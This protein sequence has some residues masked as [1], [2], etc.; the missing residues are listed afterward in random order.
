M[1]SN[2]VTAAQV[3]MNNQARLRDYSSKRF[4]SKADQGSQLRAPVSGTSLCPDPGQ[5]SVLLDDNTT[6]SLE[7]LNEILQSL[8]GG[9]RDTKHI[10]PFPAFSI[11]PN[12]SYT[13][14]IQS[15][16]RVD[17]NNEKE[18]ED[19]TDKEIAKMFIDEL[20]CNPSLLQMP[21]G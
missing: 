13:Q 15:K 9:K 11:P 20:L 12:V 17:V 10:H 7:L 6:D 4:D 2:E 21:Q 18:R 1:K 8:Q 14:G 3:V 19:R 5:P 16:Y